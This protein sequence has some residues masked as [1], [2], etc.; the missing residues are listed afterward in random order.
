MIQISGITLVPNGSQY[1][2]ENIKQLLFTLLDARA[3]VSERMKDGKFQAVDGVRLLDN[4]WAISKSLRSYKSIL[5]EINDLDAAEME[6]IQLDLVA[7]G[8]IKGPK[9]EKQL[10]ATIKLFATAVKMV[11]AGIELGKTFE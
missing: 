8:Y 10:N 2:V 4:V 5:Q 3:E 7:K 9:A 11:E 1:G 6:S